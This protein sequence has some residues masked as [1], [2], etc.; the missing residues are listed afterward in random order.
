MRSLPFVAGLAALSL[1]AP[2]W[3]SEADAGKGKKPSKSAPS[4]GEPWVAGHSLK[5][6]VEIYRTGNDGEKEQA[7]HSIA[8]CL[9]ERK[10][11]EAAKA[12][13]QVLDDP[14]YRLIACKAL[15]RSPWQGESAAA[16]VPFAS[17]KEKSF[18]VR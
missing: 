15:G 6:W 2:S 18:E 5:E 4:E 13:V 11:L 17:S 3:P 1:L 14:R 8:W 9:T 12:L 7:A 16:L 10:S